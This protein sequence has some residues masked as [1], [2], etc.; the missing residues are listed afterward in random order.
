MKHNLILSACLFSVIVCSA[1]AQ[2][3]IGYTVTDLATLG[4]TISYGY[5][6]NASG[7][8]TGVSDTTGDATFHAFLYDGTMHDLGTLGGTFSRGYGINA[9]GQVTGDADR[10]FLWT[11]T[12]PN[13]TSGMM[14]DV[15]TLGGTFSQGYGIN[16]S[17][18][19]TG[20]A[21]T[22]VD[23][24]SP[25]HAFL[26][27][28]TMHDLGTLGGK[29]SQGNGIN[30]SGQVAGWADLTGNT[31]YHAFLYD[32]TM[33]DLGTLGGEYSQGNGINDSGQVT[34]FSYTTVGTIPHAFLYDGTMHD[35]G[36]LG[37]TYSDGYGINARG[38][39]TGDA[40]TTGDAANHAFLYS[41][42]G[43]MVDLN[44]FIDP[45]SGW[46]LS[47]GN[48]I[49]DAGQITGNGTIN[50]QTHAVLLTP[51][52]PGDFNRDGHVNAGDITA[53]MEAMVDLNA[54]Q[55]DH[56]LSANELVALGDLDGDGV[57]TNADLQALLNLLQSGGGSVGNVPEPATITL[58]IIGL[59]IFA[60]LRLRYRAVR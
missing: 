11:P 1:E 3:A 6:I 58:S 10:A 36:T 13:G 26:Y 12:V 22:T 46:V 56:G 52:L 60:V 21:D 42:S 28:G 4:G 49:N 55:S 16:A 34:G 47:Q 27:D 50:G 31:P 5:G 51:L 39:V 17:G 8:V 25:S 32:G 29:Y 14:N 24:S 23:A 7:Q 59:S 20:N 53:M 43:G 35:L 37:G 30:N 9:S 33:H 57:V 19:V 44:T 38:D 48:A 41:S 54:Y 45:S 18:E 15:G 2:A 40:G